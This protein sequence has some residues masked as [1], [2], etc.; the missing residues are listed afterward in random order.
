MGARPLRLLACVL[1]SSS[2]AGGA[3]G[4][5]NA[6]AGVGSASAPDELAAASPAGL[7]HWRA[8]PPAPAAADTTGGGAAAGAAAAGLGAAATGAVAGLRVPGLSDLWA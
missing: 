7:F 3:P 6:S 1:N 2:T 8:A 4:A 5:R